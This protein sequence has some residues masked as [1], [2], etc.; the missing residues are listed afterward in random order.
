MD[1]W[2]VWMLD[3][4][5]SNPG[6]LCVCAAVPSGSTGDSLEVWRELDLER[7][8]KDLRGVLSRGI[9][10][11]AVLLLHSYTSV[12]RLV[13]LFFLYWQDPDLFSCHR[14]FHY[15]SSIWARNRLCYDILASFS[16]VGPFVSQFSL[17]MS[18]ECGLVGGS[19][20]L[21]SRAVSLILYSSTVGSFKSRHTCSPSLQTCNLFPLKKVEFEVFKKDNIDC[22]AVVELHKSFTFQL[23]HIRLSLSLF[24]SLSDG[25]ITRRL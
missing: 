15:L 7:V 22:R 3:M 23:L 4:N 8:E 16:C 21:S 6:N 12:I 11:L 10:S 2:I 18:E 20:C 9:T 24:W 25:P 13:F 5:W 14:F 1:V 19:S 17:H